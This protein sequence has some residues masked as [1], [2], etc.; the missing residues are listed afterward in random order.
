MPEHPACDCG[1]FAIGRCVDCSRA[2]CGERDC[3]VRI[4]RR[5]RCS[6]CARRIEEAD[7]TERQRGAAQRRAAEAAEQQAALASAVAA[8]RDQRA[9][10]IRRLRALADPFEQVLRVVHATR[11][12]EVLAEIVPGL[13]V[14]DDGARLAVDHESIA[15]CF[16]RAADGRL[17][18][19]SGTPGLTPPKWWLGKPRRG[20][21]I[22]A[23]RLF[24]SADG[25]AW[26][27]SPK[28]NGLLHVERGGEFRLGD[29]DRLHDLLFE[30]DPSLLVPPKPS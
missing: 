1:T 12:A 22:A 2:V 25:Q 17:P 13:R 6:E 18:Y 11:D 3:S 10:V 5:L 4:A 29:L 21:V 16:A 19:S 24:V 14:S 26:S 27:A 20:W 28:P 9:A 23:N 7:A 8:W 15:E 30:P